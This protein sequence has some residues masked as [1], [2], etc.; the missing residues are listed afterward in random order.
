MYK[1]TAAILMLISGAMSTSGAFAQAAAGDP[2]DSVG[3]ADVANAAA[4]AEALE[5]RYAEVEAEMRALQERLAV[6]A[7]DYAALGG[8]VAPMAAQPSGSIRETEQEL[9]RLEVELAALRRQFTEMLLYGVEPGKVLYGTDWPISSMA[10]YLKF[11]DELTLP[12][13]DRRRILYDNAAALFGLSAQDS[14]FPP[15]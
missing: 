7:R 1:T 4:R 15:A 14:M 3:A 8:A 2:P 10:S 5:A 6:L 9:A 12:V 11:V 13:A